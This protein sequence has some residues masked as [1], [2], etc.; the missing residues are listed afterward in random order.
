M[1][2][3]I[4]SLTGFVAQLPTGISFNIIFVRFESFETTWEDCD[5]DFVSD[6]RRSEKVSSTLIP[7]FKAAQEIRQLNEI[8]TNLRIGFCFEEARKDIDLQS[9]GLFGYVLIHIQKVESSALMNQ[10]FVNGKG[11]LVC[12]PGPFR[13]HSLNCYW[14]CSTWNPANALYQVIKKYCRLSF[15]EECF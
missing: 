14:N 5:D 10:D 8:V 9:K 1:Q 7:W 15:E 2:E 12:T 6:R 3:Q 4:L 11:C 13:F